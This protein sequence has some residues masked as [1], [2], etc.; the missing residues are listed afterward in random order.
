MKK[1]DEVRWQVRERYGNIARSGAGCGCA[2]AAGSSCC[3]S[4]PA[5]VAAQAKKIGYSEAE[6]KAAPEGANLGLGCGNPGAIA[7]L[8][9]GEVVLDLGA[10]GGFD[11]FLAAAKVGPKG[12][13]IGVDMTADMVARARD[14]AARDG[15]TNVEFRL[16]EIEHLPVADNTVDAVISNCVVN[17]SPDKPQVY[18][19]VF[20]VLKPG[21]RIALS[22]TV[23][24]QDFPPA[25]MDN[26]ALL[27]S[28]VTGSASPAEIEAMLRAAGF[29]AI[30]VRIKPESR[31]AVKGWAPG[32]GVE[33]Y[34][35]SADILARKPS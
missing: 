15:I 6:L 27:C 28:C 4:A 32:S 3:G 13:V 10:G 29:T 5:G 16:G 2:P 11:C 20:R 25:W 22:D 9:P 33:D 21:G 12:R 19:E 17:L 8:A 31:E 34:V 26:A 24:L 14:N 23:R 18:Q 7:A 35:A 1:D 30:E